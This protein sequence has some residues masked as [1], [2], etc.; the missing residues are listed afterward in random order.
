MAKEELLQVSGLLYQ[1]AMSYHKMLGS[2]KVVY[3]NVIGFRSGENR[4]KSVP[5]QHTRQ[6]QNGEPGTK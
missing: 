2:S 4:P 1:R 6:E 3:E 5:G